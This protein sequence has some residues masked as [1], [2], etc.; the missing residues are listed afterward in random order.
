MKNYQPNTLNRHTRLRGGRIT[1]AMLC[2]MALVATVHKSYA[3]C[4]TWNQLVNTNN[5]AFTS[6]YGD[7]SA[8]DVNNCIY[9]N[10]NTIINLTRYS[11][12]QMLASN[13]PLPTLGYQNAGPV[14]SSIADD[15]NTFIRT[16]TT[17]V[18]N[19]YKSGVGGST[20]VPISTIKT[21]VTARSTSEAYAIN[22][23]NGL[24]YQY[25]SGNGNFNGWAG[26][27]NA[28][29]QIEVATDGTLFALKANGNV[30]KWNGGSWVT[31][32]TAAYTSIEA[33]N[34]GVIYV[35]NSSGH[36]LRY[37]PNTG[38]VTLSTTPS[39]AK[40][41][42][43]NDGTLYAVGTTTGNIY[44][45]DAA[46]SPTIT[47]AVNPCGGA[48]LTAA[49]PTGATP[50]QFAW[51]TGASTASTTVANTGT[52]TITIT[53]ANSCS[54]TATVNV[55]AV[56][57][58]TTLSNSTLIAS[59]PMS[60]NGNNA[61]SNNWNA[62]VG[63]ATTLTTDRN[64]ATDKAYAFNGT[65]NAYLDMGDITAMNGDTGL[66]VS[67]WFMVSNTQASNEFMGKANA[68][69]GF[70]VSSNFGTFYIFQNATPTP[71]MTYTQLGIVNNQWFHMAYR[72]IKTGAASG[73]ARVYINGT[74]VAGVTT[75]SATAPTIAGTTFRIG[76]SP[77]IGGSNLNG[78]ADDIQ[79][80]KKALS[81]SEIFSLANNAP[82]FAQ[83]PTDTVSIC[84]N[85]SFTLTAAADDAAAT[86][87]WQ[88]NGT[89][90]AGET[91]PTF[92]KNNAT[93]G[94][95]GQYT[96]VITTGCMTTSSRIANVLVNTGNVSIT[97]QPQATTKCLGQQATFTV[98]ATGGTGYQWKKNGVDING[99]TAATLTISNIALTDTGTY[100]CEV[101][102]GNCGAIST[103]GA[104][105]TVST[106]PSVSINPASITICAGSVA[107]LTASGGTGYNWS[108]NGGTNATATFSP[109]GN[110]TYTVTATDAVGCTATAAKQVNVTPLPQA[111]VSF[112]SS[113]FIC[114]GTSITA[115]A[116]GGGTYAW[117]NGSTGSSITV[118]PTVTT[119][120]TV[121][122][123]DNNC[124]ATSSNVVTV[125]TATAI[126]TQPQAQ[127]TCTGGS[128]TLTVAA[129][130]AN[131]T[132]QWKKNGNNVG[133]GAASYTISN[134]T[135]ND[136]GTYTVDVTGDC[137]T[138]I[139]NDAVVTIVGSLQI[140]QQPQS[141][142]VCAGSNTTLSIVA[143]GASTTYTWK[144]DGVA[145][146]NANASTLTLN[147]VS[148]NNAGVYTVEVTSNCGNATSTA[149]TLTVALPSTA[150]I[151]ESVCYGSSFAFN[152]QTLTQ[153]GTYRDTL[154]NTLGCDS[155]V[156]LNLAV[157]NQATGTL[158]RSICTGQTFS[159]NG[160]E[161]TQTGTYYDTLQTAQGCDS[162]LTLNLSVN[163]FVT[164]SA[165]AAVCQGDSY[166][167]N[168]QQLTQAGQYMDTLTSVGGCDSIVT[169]TLTVNA[170]PQPVITQTGNT[171]TTGAYSTYQ[172]LVDDNAIIGANAQSHTATQNGSYTVL[173][174]DA[175]GCSNTSTA[176]TVTTVGI[177][178]L[179][180]AIQVR[181]YP[182]P[183]AGS[184]QISSNSN[185]VF[186]YSLYDITGRLIDADT[187][188]QST[189]VNLTKVVQ[190][191]YIMLLKDRNGNTN[192][193]QL[194]K[195]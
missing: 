140:T 94:D 55:T 145:I 10:G 18:N 149:A 151:A 194:S 77:I 153:S 167:F 57:T 56:G 172:W 5:V 139:S 16:N 107:T 67:A 158:N 183:F 88:K 128:L 71:G 134:A 160:T 96:C 132:Y 143:N 118:S 68:S 1:V 83:H 175:D 48:T 111:F 19:I 62:T 184:L 86:Y 35:T 191:S 146:P 169:L 185:E 97:T 130:G 31:H 108:N 58:A 176:I 105:L 34:G 129:N 53:D 60:G 164:A 73:E 59:Y 52:Y 85:N 120:Y 69:N 179:P 76:E 51:S 192:K 13:F 95:A 38:L 43:A 114:P 92:T 54:G 12:V 189:T 115:N 3:Q 74:Y 90:I 37:H 137:G 36:V 113:P 188:T 39:I 82:L 49:A 157:K 23:N 25:T 166:S 103:N 4:F 190:G 61:V 42:V 64:S 141:E 142:T 195:Q 110:T 148:A 26:S 98:A 11:G 40:V 117:S 174:T 30:D 89:N 101:S 136:A 181:V 193:Y 162:L 186:E 155:F 32:M 8:K 81:V 63:S 126:T 14:Q 75:S 78:K 27:V 125:K 29:T 123:T 170:L 102:G 84:A 135:S 44:R 22:I 182:N 2:L 180:A 79:I 156:V 15:G 150:T 41:S 154:V 131:L 177:P 178:T 152:G 104:Y 6:P 159:F 65:A 24:S 109:S 119:T 80:F 9:A 144:K 127:S 122:V 72:Y 21:Y 138:V 17:A 106:G 7:I 20:P 165:D 91:A 147:N 133:T 100:T 121:T 66:T 168:G 173:V 93:T 70:G 99:Q 116:T 124:S 163:S 161:L 45:W 47:Q 28:Y 187:F 112:T 50:L 46:V 87:Q 171:L 33:A